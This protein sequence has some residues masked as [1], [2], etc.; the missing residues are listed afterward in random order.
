MT[1]LLTPEVTAARL[2]TIPL[3]RAG[4]PSDVADAVR[5]LCGTGSSYV[6]GTTIEVAG[7]RGL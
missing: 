3:G 6:T 5:W 2:E 7:G 4:Q 1:A